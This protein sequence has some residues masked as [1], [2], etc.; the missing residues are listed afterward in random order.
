[1]ADVG[2]LESPVRKGVRVRIPPLA[3]VLALLALCAPAMADEA[4]DPTTGACDV[5]E[6]VTPPR[7]R[8]LFAHPVVRLPGPITQG[9]V[10]SLAHIPTVAELTLGPGEVTTLAPLRVLMRLATLRID[11]KHVA[12]LATAGPLPALRRLEI[13]G[14]PESLPG[15]A[16]FVGLEELVLHGPLDCRT[17]LEKLRGA[18][19]L[20][21]IIATGGGKLPSLDGLDGV[22]T[23]ME[24]QLRGVRI[25]EPRALAAL[26]QLRRLEVESMG[27]LRP[28]AGL[29][30]LEALTI[31]PGA[32]GKSLRAIDLA[33][34]A[35]LPNLRSLTLGS[36]EVVSLRS[37][38]ASRSLRVL[39]L[40]GKCNYDF[41]TLPHT[42]ESVTVT[43][44]SV[45]KLERWDIDVF[46]RVRFRVSAAP[47]VTRCE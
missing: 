27:D 1:M 23:L 7:A 10:D 25:G 18:P 36:H 14:C 40:D 41:F 5:R 22:P 38:R 3:P 21:K 44:G 9:H 32:A 15:V 45:P 8:A 24:L 37:L 2:D 30:N 33:P 20:K 35:A 6:P 13:I 39:S 11:V 43:G 17:W 26:H 4:C 46:D 19:K 12:L 29:T 42:L 34:L 31:D 47:G 16:G 28:L